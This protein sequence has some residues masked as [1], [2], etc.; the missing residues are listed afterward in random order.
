[1]LENSIIGMGA[2]NSATC[3]DEIE[4]LLAKVSQMPRAVAQNRTGKILPMLII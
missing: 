1:M 4:T 2:Y 3:D